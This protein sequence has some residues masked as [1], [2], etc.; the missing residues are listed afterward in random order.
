MKLAKFNPHEFDDNN[1]IMNENELVNYI[2]DVRSDE[3]FLNMIGTNRH[4]EQL[5]VKRTNATY[6]FMYLLLKLSL[7]IL[8]NINGNNIAVINLLHQNYAVVSYIRVLNDLIKDQVLND[9]FCL[10]H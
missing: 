5:S 8:N 1:I 10:V 9:F 3:N 4:G 7:I 2:R 6:L